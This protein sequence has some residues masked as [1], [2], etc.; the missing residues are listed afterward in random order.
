MDPGSSI[1]P[2]W[3]PRRGLVEILHIRDGGRSWVGAVLRGYLS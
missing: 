1:K 2:F 3:P